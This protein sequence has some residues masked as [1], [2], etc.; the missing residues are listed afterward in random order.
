MVGFPVNKLNKGNI[1]IGKSF[2][3][4]LIVFSISFYDILISFCLSN[5]F[6]FVRLFLTQLIRALSTND[7]N[8]LVQYF[9][10]I[11]MSLFVFDEA[12]SS[13]IFFTFL[14]IVMSSVFSKLLPP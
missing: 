8:L 10:K 3:E 11:D 9:L 4:S 1:D 6:V 13:R 2:Y 5:W 7:G 12:F 14:K